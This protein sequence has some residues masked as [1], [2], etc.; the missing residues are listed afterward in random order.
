M[1]CAQFAPGKS[2]GTAVLNVDLSVPNAT[3]Y[4]NNPAGRWGPYTLG[5]MALEVLQDF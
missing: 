2:Q 5:I 3:V 4:T 1:E